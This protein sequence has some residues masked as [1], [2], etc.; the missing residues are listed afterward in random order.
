MVEHNKTN[1][2]LPDLPLNML[3][4]TNKNRTRVTLRINIKMFEGNNLPHELLLTTRQKNSV[5]NAFGNNMSTDVKFSKSQSPKII[6]YGGFLRSLLIKMKGPSMKV[7]ILLAK[8]TLAPLWITA[9][10]SAIN[11]GIQNK[12]H[13]CGTVT[14]IIS[15]K[16]MNDMIEIV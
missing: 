1:V 16:E 10:A 4:P 5:R 15:N 13:G 12:I 9:T 6:Q 8:N 3:Q 11:A 14:L 2:K 7:A